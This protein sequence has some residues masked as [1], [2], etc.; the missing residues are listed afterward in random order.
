MRRLVSLLIKAAIS[1]LL[2]YVSLR[3]VN[4]SAVGER[5]HG[6]QSGWV[7][8]MLILLIAQ[9]ALLALRWRRI[10]LT[11]G[12]VLSIGAALRYSMT[13]IFFNQALPSTVGGDGARI[14]LLARNGAGW[15]IATYSV[16]IDRGVGLFALAVLVVGCLP[17]TLALVREPVG[18]I[19]LIVIGLGSIAGA[20]AFLAFAFAP[21]RWMDRFW[22]TRHLAAAAD[23][24][25]R[26][27]R[28]I[29]SALLVAALSLAIHLL[30]VAAVWAAAKAI[31]APLDFTL[32]LYLVPPVILVATVPVSIAGWGLRESAMIVAFAYAGLAESD[33]LIVS[34]LFGAATFIVGAIGGI[35]WVLSGDKLGAPPPVETLE[36]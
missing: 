6:L 35:V 32:A 33:G 27:C 25:W 23:I 34:V 20:F 15:K 13:A 29:D 22:A 24:S 12:A 1:A 11:S 2:L 4:L 14:W 26:L 3:S 17:W 36:S 30:T 7:A 28:S 18:R 5:L 10:V 9:I 19:A 16:L 21:K 31:A 8:V